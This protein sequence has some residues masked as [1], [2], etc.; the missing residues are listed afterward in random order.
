MHC[1]RTLPFSVSTEQLQLGTECSRLILAIID[2]KAQTLGAL[3]YI[4]NYM[5]QTKQHA[6]DQYK[7]AAKYK[8]KIILMVEVKKGFTELIGR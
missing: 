6:I 1:S 8:R 7:N 2:H 5:T 4:S 3:I